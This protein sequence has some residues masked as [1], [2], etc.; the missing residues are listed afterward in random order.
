MAEPQASSIAADAI[1]LAGAGEFGEAIV[2]LTK[3][4][5]DV[6]HAK[7]MRAVKNAFT[8]QWPDGSEN[9]ADLFEGAALAGGDFGTALYN[10]G[11]GLWAVG[12]LAGALSAFQTGADEGSRDAQLALGISALWIGDGPRGLGSLN[13]LLDEDDEIGALAAAAIGRH[14][15]Q[16][17]RVTAET[18]RFLE[19]GIKNDGDYVPDLADAYL[20]LDRL[21]EAKN[22]LV[23]QSAMGNPVAPIA[24]GNLYES[25]LGDDGLAEQAFRRGIELEDAHSAYNLAALL[26][27]LGQAAESQR[28]L[29]LAA[30]MGDDRATQRLAS[31]S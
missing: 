28:F 1:R 2:E 18:A 21:E 11:A 31:F 30:S 3:L 27:R 17:N 12:D 22:L 26:D 14:H 6:G 5:E 16:V 10:L 7:F 13:M 29:E 9:A 20:K 25:R 24:L 8:A 19:R 15:V 23:E 4:R